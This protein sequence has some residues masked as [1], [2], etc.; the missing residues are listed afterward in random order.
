M[1]EEDAYEREGEDAYEREGHQI[2]RRTPEGAVPIPQNYFIDSV[3][4]DVF[5]GTLDENHKFEQFFWTKETVEALVKGLAFVYE[6]KTCCLT[7]PSLAHRW[8]ELGRDEVLLD[9]DTRFSY[10]PKFHYFDIRKPVLPLQEREADDA[11][12]EG[13]RLLVLDPPFFIIP[14]EKIREAVDLITG[15]DLETKLI[16]GWLLRAE[17]S[18]RD[19]FRPYNL[20]PTTFPLQYASIKPNKWKNFRLYSNI[21]L[22]GIKRI[23]E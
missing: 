2:D 8:H 20:V 19:A 7:T 11:G 14:I 6:E 1:Q 13:F 10:L 5:G 23:R 16:I 22:P 12:E 15:G 17:K 9:I 4:T 21:D 18:L 3:R